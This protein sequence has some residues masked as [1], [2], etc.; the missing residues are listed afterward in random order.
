M[1][2]ESV[3]SGIYLGAGSVAQASYVSHPSSIVVA[4][5]GRIGSILTLNVCA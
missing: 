1:S 3:V 2:T 5:E 4:S